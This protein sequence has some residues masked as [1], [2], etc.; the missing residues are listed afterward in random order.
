MYI[1]RSLLLFLGIALL[2]FPTLEEWMISSG[3]PWYRLYLLWLI[4]VVAAYW[5]QRS[6]YPDEL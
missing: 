3:A 2:F 4:A 5:N 6:R 1:N